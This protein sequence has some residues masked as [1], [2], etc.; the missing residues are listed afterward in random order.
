MSTKRELNLSKTLLTDKGIFEITKFTTLDFPNNLAC[1]LWFAKCNMF[2]RYCYNPEIVRGE[3]RYTNEE[4]LEFLKTRIG[5][6][7]G[8]VLSGGECTLYPHLIELCE[9]IKEL[10]FKIKVDTNGLK[11]DVI[12]ELIECSLIDFVALDY[13]APTEK[14]TQ[15]TKVQSNEKFYKTLDFLIDKN[16]PFE[17]RTTVHSELLASSDINEIIRDLK[18]R[19]YKGTYYLQNFLEV[20]NTLGDMDIPSIPIDKTLLLGDLPIEIRNP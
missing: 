18:K 13:K 20:Q 17:I 6:L 14:F 11:P 7:T 16:F 5:K 12:K 3:G 8:V 10:G 2:C 1:I 4:I 19:K 9:E 15:I